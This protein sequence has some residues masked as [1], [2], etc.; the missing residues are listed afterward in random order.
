MSREDLKIPKKR[1]EVMLWVH[2]TGPTVGSIFLY[3]HGH[4]RRDTED[5]ARV[6]NHEFPFI[7]VEHE[8]REELAFYN[9]ESIV[10]VE[11][12][13]KGA[14]AMVN[15]V[16]LPCRIQMRDGSTIDGVIRESMPPEKSR[17][18]DYL[19]Q[20][21]DRFLRLHIDEHYR[22]LVNKSYIVRVVPRESAGL[23]KTARA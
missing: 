14:P 15:P 16:E 19:S 2:P 3:F 13:D 4:S 10:R 12:A 11:Y 7:V 20:S 6:L 9:K 17:L 23:Q 1:K 5:P 21:E 18:F 8:D 22:C